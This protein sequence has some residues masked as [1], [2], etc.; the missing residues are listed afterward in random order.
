MSAGTDRGISALLSL[1]R[2]GFINDDQLRTRL[3]GIGYSDTAIVGFLISAAWMREADMH[4][5]V[6]TEW[7]SAYAKDLI[8]ES[9]LRS[10]LAQLG[11]ASDRIDSYISIQNLKKQPTPKRKAPTPPLPLYQQPAGQ[12]D[13]RRLTM[14]Y[15]NGL[16]DRGTFTSS[17]RGLEMPDELVRA[18]VDLSDARKQV[19]ALR[20]A[21]PPTPMYDTEAGRLNVRTLLILFSIDEISEDDLRA[22]LAALEMESDLIDA[23]VANAKAEA[24]KRARANE[25]TY[26]VFETGSPQSILFAD[27]RAAYRR[28]E[29]SDEQFGQVLITLG[30]NPD[31][32][33]A[34]I[35]AESL[36]RQQAPVPKPT[37]TPPYAANS[38][39]ALLY[40]NALT[41]YRQGTI[42]DSALHDILKRLG[43][44]E[45]Q[46]TQIISAEKLVRR[47]PEPPAPPVVPPWPARSPESILFANSR[48]AY[49]QLRIDDSEYRSILVYLGYT[50]QQADQIIA[51]DQL[52]RKA[53]SPTA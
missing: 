13:V 27:S 1:Y 31:D 45:N 36:V 12:V 25:S 48:T 29:I 3:R 21:K 32:A 5:Q 17:L 8:S 51:A 20:G 35:E 24:T 39:Q 26:P 52:V 50:P 7:T 49:R 22:G 6:V 43:Y 38:P 10:S 11:W 19:A 4:G 9:T 34:I 37:F 18:T 28:R 44:D 47:V 14:S 30:Y 42:D 40:S 15:E 16:I 33:R 2:D 46:A 53:T 23:T 41:A